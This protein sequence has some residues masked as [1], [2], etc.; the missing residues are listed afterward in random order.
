[1]PKEGYKVVTVKEQLHDELKEEAK[2]R[3]CSIPKLIHDLLEPLK[4]SSVEAD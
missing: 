2:R 1:M 4:K 3:K